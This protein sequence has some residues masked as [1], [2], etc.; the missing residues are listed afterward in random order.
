MD[1][2]IVQVIART[3]VLYTIN[4]IDT[5]KMLDFVILKR[6]MLARELEKNCCDLLLTLNDR[7][8]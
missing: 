1:N 4:D 8:F 2:L 5:N 7:K 6:G 3:C